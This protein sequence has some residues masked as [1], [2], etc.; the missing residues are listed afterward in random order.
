MPVVLTVLSVLA[1]WA[2]LTV[3]IIALL[4]IRR[5]LEGVRRNLE[6]IT[7]GVRAIEVETAPLGTHAIRTAGTLTALA[8]HVA[9][10]PDAIAAIESQVAALAPELRRLAGGVRA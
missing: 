1:G 8:A 6:Q 2:F 9:A 10:L 5:V 4:L 3:L 7:M